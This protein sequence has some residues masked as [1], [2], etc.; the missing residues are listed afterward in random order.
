[1]QVQVNHVKGIHTSIFLSVVIMLIIITV[2]GDDDD[3]GEFG[4][5]DNE[6]DL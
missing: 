6:H 3:F 1:M 5:G 4:D 2:I